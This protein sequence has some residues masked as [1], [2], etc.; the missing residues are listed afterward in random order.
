MVMSFGE[1]GCGG[2]GFIRPT[3]GTL[4]LD[5]EEIIRPD[6][7]RGVVF[8]KHALMP[9]LNVVQNATLGLKFNKGKSSLLPWLN[10]VD[11]TTLG[12]KLNKQVS[13]E[14]REQ[15][16]L[17]KLKLVGLQ[18]FAYK[19]IYELSGGTKIHLQFLDTILPGL[20]E[21]TKSLVAIKIASSILCVI[22]KI[23]FSVFFQTCRI[24]SCTVSLVN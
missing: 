3:S 5:G 8:Q 23:S 22:K 9:W 4:L 1:S 19:K 14:E 6:S 16:G 15:I 13:S 20:G 2:A 17:E 18:D 7:D 21:R 11:N 24:N 12:M 10:V